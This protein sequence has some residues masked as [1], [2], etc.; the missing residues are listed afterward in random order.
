MKFKAKLISGKDFI[1][2]SEKHS[3]NLLRLITLVYLIPTNTH[4]KASSNQL[5]M[6]I[7][8]SKMTSKILDKH[9]NLGS[10]TN[11]CQEHG[12][13]QLGFFFA[14]SLLCLQGRISTI[15]WYFWSLS[16]SSAC[17]P[18]ILTL[19]RS[20]RAQAEYQC[21]APPGRQ[22]ICIYHGRNTMSI[23]KKQLLPSG[24]QHPRAKTS[25]TNLIYFPLHVPEV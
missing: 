25:P 23:C 6:I 19:M 2:L 14:F 1:I 12:I 16:S 22:H 13:F 8:K 21:I 11:S 10:K 15:S 7:K 9:G 3:Y 24:L 4:F 17:Q 5:F 20:Q 18:N